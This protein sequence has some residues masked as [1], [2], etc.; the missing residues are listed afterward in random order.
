TRCGSLGTVADAECGP[1]DPVRDKSVDQCAVLLE[2]DEV[3]P[4]DI[5][6]ARLGAIRSGDRHQSLLVGD[7]RE[8]TQQDAFNPT[9]DRGVRADPKSQAKDRHDRKARTATQHT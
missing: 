5:G 7:S 8:W 9:E 2:I 6:V 1:G 3:G 4:S